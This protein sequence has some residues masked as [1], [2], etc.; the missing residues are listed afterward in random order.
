MVRFR[1]RD[2][3]I[4]NYTT[5]EI[6]NMSDKELVDLLNNYDWDL[7]LTRDLLWRAHR[8][9]PDWSLNAVGLD[10]VRELQNSAEALGQHLIY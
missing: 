9:D 7:D 6:E 10:L 2:L 4:H 1:D 8:N 3:P 5:E